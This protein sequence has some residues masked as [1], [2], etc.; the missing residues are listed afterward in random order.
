MYSRLWTYMKKCFL[1]S[2]AYVFVYVPTCAFRQNHLD[3]LRPLVILI[4]L[5]LFFLDVFISSLEALFSLMAQ[6][7]SAMYEPS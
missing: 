2:F 3:H 5:P 4:N 6:F 7:K 1:Q